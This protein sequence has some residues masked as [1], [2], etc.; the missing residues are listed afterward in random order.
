MGHSS[1][2]IIEVNN[3]VKQYKKSDSPA[4]N[5]VS[6]YVDEG[7]FFALL[8]PN[9]AGKTT[10]LQILTT[11]LAKTS[12][13]VQ[14]AGCDVETE[15]DQVRQLIGV[16]FQNPS[17]DLN[18]SAEENI[19]FH[20]N[21]YNMFPY[22]P[23]F[24]LM[25]QVYKDQVLSLATVLGIQ[26]DLHKPV[27]SFSGGMKRKL[28]IVRSLMHRPKVLFLDEPTT[29]LDPISRA[30]LWKYLQEVRRKER[31]T[32][33]LTTHYLEEAESAD[34]L[35]IM[36]NGRIVA[37]G[38]VSEVKKTLVNSY[39]ELDAADAKRLRDELKIRQLSFNGTGPYRVSLNGLDAASVIQSTK[40]PLTHVVIHTPTLEEAYVAIIEGQQHE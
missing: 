39:V 25:P 34:Y 13:S 40:T 35:C 6:F 33:F 31:V 36:N 18:L 2:R 19:R 3:L 28:E 15:A 21:L 4:V 7:T 24:A 30:N 12:G 17:L 23:T 27:K 16:I 8:G 29:G 5:S 22:R 37:K 11:I 26:H 32:I 14:V 38:T 9:G 10:T 20:T 1:Q